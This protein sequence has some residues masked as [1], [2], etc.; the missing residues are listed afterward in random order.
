MPL[1][2]MA[3]M[4]GDNIWIARDGEMVPHLEAKYVSDAELPI[5]PFELQIAYKLRLATPKD[6]EDAVHLYSMFEETLS[7]PKLEH[8]VAELGVEEDYERLKRA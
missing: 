8:W 7:I 3:E 2:A 5:G 1:D 4:L 6:F